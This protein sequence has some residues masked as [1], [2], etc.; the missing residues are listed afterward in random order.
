MAE[1]SEEVKCVGLVGLAR[2]IA[3]N[4]MLRQRA[5]DHALLH[6]ECEKKKG[7]IS[8]ENLALNV[9]LIMAVLR[10]WL[11]QLTDSTKTVNIDEVREQV[12]E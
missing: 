2:I 9:D 12:G 1:P 4:A 6:W 5:L 10:I 3:N 8:Q 11:P 7:L